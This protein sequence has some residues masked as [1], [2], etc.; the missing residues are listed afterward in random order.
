VDGQENTWSNSF[1]Q[2]YQEVQSDFTESN[3]GLVDYAVVVNADWWNGLS[4]EIRTG[5]TTALE[6]ATALNN[7]IAE[8]LNQDA[9]AKI[10][11]SN[12][13]TI[14]Q[15]TPEQRAAWVEAMQPVWNQFED[16]IGADLIE[17]AGSANQ[18]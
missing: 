18:N 15:L 14:H 17:A 10:A 5:L 11:E 2:K 12:G 13:V 9:R 4:D 16:E 8:K 3:H 6:E 7:E 1:S